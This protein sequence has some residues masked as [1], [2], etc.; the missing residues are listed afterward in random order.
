MIR[1]LLMIAGAGFVLSVASISAAVAIGGPEAMARGGWSIFAHDWGELGWDWDQDEHHDAW[2]TAGRH[3]PEATRTL[4]WTGAESLD[5][6]L[7][8]DVRYVQAEGAGSVT[9]T[10]PQRLV[11]R[12]VVRG[13]SIRYEHGRRSGRGKLEIVVRAPGVTR[14][15]LGGRNTLAIEGY[16]QPRLAL[17]IS[18]DAEVKAEGATEDL[19][20]D[21]SGDGEADLGGL[22]TRDARADISGAGEVTLSPSESARLEVSGVAD[23]RLLTRPKRLETDI[24]GA[25]RVRQPDEGDVAAPAAP[26]TPATPGTK[27]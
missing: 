2:E 21:I 24:S 16:R 27:L 9:V 22:K 13:D 8:A 6:D 3:G 12:V 20:L 26:A 15:D 1:P 4:S 23:V 18:G 5:I 19:E 14:F 10:G 7:P 25:A 17:D 11:D